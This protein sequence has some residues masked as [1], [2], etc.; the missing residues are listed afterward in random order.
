MPVINPINPEK[1]QDKSDGKTD[2]SKTDNKSDDNKTDN[3]TNNG[4]NNDDSNNNSENNNES[5]NDDSGDDNEN[6]DTPDIPE[7]FE[8]EE[9]I[10]RD[11]NVTWSDITEA[12][13]FSSSMYEFGDKIAPESFNTY[14]FAVKNGTY[15]NLKYEIKFIE[16]NP[17]NI[18]MKYKLKKNDTYIVD[19]YVSAD[20]LNISD[21]L[22]DART[23]DTYYLEWK[24][25]SSSNDTEIGSNLNSTYDL[26]IQVNAESYDD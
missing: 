8:S 26:Q 4:S 17:Y 19:H 15:Y 14:K 2:N 1:E 16:S 21:M 6:T 24:W 3:E 22:L 25:I 9:L 23:S 5:N 13:I 18:N 10:V 12:K 20:E 11:K 7:E